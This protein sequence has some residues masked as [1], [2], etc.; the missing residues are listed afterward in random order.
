V[1]KERKG[2]QVLWTKNFKLLVDDIMPTRP[3][4]RLWGSFPGHVRPIFSC[5]SSAALEAIGV[6]GWL[7]LC[8]ETPQVV[9][10]GRPTRVSQ[11]W[12]TKK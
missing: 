10:S 12:M 8:D 2:G 5:P 11:D 7:Q 1:G 3:E 6:E 9:D 4:A